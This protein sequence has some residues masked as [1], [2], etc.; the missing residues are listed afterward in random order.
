MSGGHLLKSIP[1]RGRTLDHAAFAYDLVEPFFMLGRQTQYVQKIISFLKLKPE[2]KVLDLGC[3]TGVLT[4]AIGDMLDAQSGGVSIGI[5]AA[6]KM[7][8]VAKKK[9]ENETCRFEL[10]AAEE[11]PY[12]DSYFDSVVSSLFY[13]HLPLDLKEKSLTEAYRVL[14]P[15]GRLVV[16]DMHSPDS[17]FGKLVSCVAR[18]VLL[19]PEI[20]ENIRGVLPGLIGKAGFDTPEKVATYFGYIAVFT[21]RKR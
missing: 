3:G 4:R 16:A 1:T 15:E 10:A 13:H 21:T 7:I 8:A 2:Y 6:A 5:D 19:Q 14:K 9:R 12:E 18:Y 20:A 11:L 17:F